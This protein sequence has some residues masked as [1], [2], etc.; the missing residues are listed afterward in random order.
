MTKP[1]SDEKFR[2]GWS[3]YSRSIRFSAA[4]KELQQTPNKAIL[5]KQGL[6]L[7]VTSFQTGTGRFICSTEDHER[8]LA[9]WL[10]EG[11]IFT[12]TP[13]TEGATAEEAEQAAAHAEETHAKLVPLG[14]HA[15]DNLPTHTL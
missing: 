3:G 7:V 6:N 12:T 1:P 11:N 15:A 9:Y 5:Q 10:H 13:P 8:F 4:L 2:K 14:L